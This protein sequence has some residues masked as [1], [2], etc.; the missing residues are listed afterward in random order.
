MQKDSG[1]DVDDLGEKMKDCYKLKNNEALQTN[2][3]KITK[4]Y[5]HIKV[6]NIM[7]K[8]LGKI[9]PT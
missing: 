2:A 7:M 4:H 5:S 9:A 6:A 3:Q 8:R 1:I